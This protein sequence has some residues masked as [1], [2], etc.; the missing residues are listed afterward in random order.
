MHEVHDVDGRKR[1]SF[2]V[3]H[4]KCQ[5]ERGMV[6]TTAAGRIEGRAVGLL[7][8]R[9]TTEASSSGGRS[10]KGRRWSFRWLPKPQPTPRVSFAKELFR[11][12]KRIGRSR[13]TYSSSFAPSSAS[14]A[15]E[16]RGESEKEGKGGGRKK[17][18]HLNLAMFH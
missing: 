3:M 18:L 2:R 8:E 9:R 14:G 6:S 10:I 7:G 16:I 17:V 12:S 1:S 11:D 13:V 4:P 5:Q 15:G